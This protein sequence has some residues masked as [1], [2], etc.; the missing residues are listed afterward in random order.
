[1]YFAVFVVGPSVTLHPIER[2]SSMLRFTRRFFQAPL[3]QAKSVLVTYGDAALD[4][5]CNDFD[6]GFKVQHSKHL[7]ADGSKFLP[8]FC[9]SKQDV[10]P[11]VTLMMKVFADSKQLENMSFLFTLAIEELEEVPEELFR[12]YFLSLCRFDT[13]NRDELVNLLDFAKCFDVQL[14]FVSLLCVVELALRLGLDP[15][16]YIQAA[17]LTPPDPSPLTKHKLSDLLSALVLTH[18]N[19][20][21]ITALLD[22]CA[23]H[24]VQG[25]SRQMEHLFR[26]ATNN[27]SVPAKHLA[28][29][30]AAVV[31]TS[32]KEISPYNLLRCVSRCIVCKDLLALEGVRK[33]LHCGKILLEGDGGK[34]LETALSIARVSIIADCGVFNPTFEELEKE[35]LTQEHVGMSPHPINVDGVELV[36]SALGNKLA[37]AIGRQGSEVI[38]GCFYHLECQRDKGATVTGRSLDV[39]VAACAEAG[40]FTRAHNTVNAYP[41]FKVSPTANTFACYFKSMAPREAVRKHK[42]I[43]AEM[44]RVGV[45]PNFDVAQIMLSQCMEASNLEAALWVV[46]VNATFHIPIERHNSSQLMVRLASMADRAGC[47]YLIKVLKE[48]KS[49]VD[50]RYTERLATQLGKMGLEL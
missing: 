35:T 32:S 16:V 14:S 44:L 28:D 9:Q 41:S 3:A 43:I 10:V 1:M 47:Q 20:S 2:S 33:S 18:S 8:T 50:E 39:I 42:D 24:H 12:I 36:T 19:S 15:S 34:Q 17:S 48:T 5:L 27:S 37:A 49:S 21:S 4:K 45:E 30:L 25:S 6:E 38:D 29:L 11:Y 40:D 13:F 31:A 23:R 7:R 46:R 26:L 22:L